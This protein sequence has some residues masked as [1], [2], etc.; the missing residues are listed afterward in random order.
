MQTTNSQATTRTT[1]RAANGTTGRATPQ[2]VRFIAAEVANPL[3]DREGERQ[4]VMQWVE[5][6][7]DYPKME[8]RWV[9][10]DAR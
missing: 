5:T 2:A 4:L 1:A 3:A 8:A 7:K 10:D 6:G 9:Y